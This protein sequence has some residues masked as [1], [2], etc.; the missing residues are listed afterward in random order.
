MVHARRCDLVVIAGRVIVIHLGL[1]A[2]VPDGRNYFSRVNSLSIRAK[3]HLSMQRYFRSD[4]LDAFHRA[5]LLKPP[6]IA[7]LTIR[8]LSQPIIQTHEALGLERAVIS[9]SDGN[10]SFNSN[11]SS[12]TFLFRRV[13]KC[14]NGVMI[15]RSRLR[16]AHLLSFKIF[17]SLYYE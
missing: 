8:R 10:R 17:F 1:V 11:G 2:I 7:P 15:F 4:L 6:T 3:F 13:Q 5:F 14:G 16:S 9:R 12:G